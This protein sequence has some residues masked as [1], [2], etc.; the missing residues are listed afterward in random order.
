MAKKTSE[1]KTRR[2]A[3]IVRNVRARYDAAQLTREN[4]RH[5][6]NADAYDAVRANES[7]VRSRL[8]QNARYE[9]A[10]NSYAK[11]IVLTLA[12][13]LIGSGPRLQII[14]DN[15]SLNQEIEGRFEEW[16]RSIDL[17]GKL[18][19]MRMA[20]CQDG[21]AFGLM[22][23]N[24]AKNG[25]TLDLRLLEAD[26]VDSIDSIGGKYVQGIN[27]DENGNPVSY[28]VLKNHP[29]GLNPTY[30]DYIDVPAKFMLHW[31]RA[32]RP[33]QIRGV[34]EITPALPLFAHL[35]RY[36][37][38]VVTTAE[39]IAEFT[40]FLKSNGAPD[41]VPTDLRAA[42]GGD[43]AEVQ[44]E[45][46]MLTTLPEG[47]EP[48]QL[49]SEQPGTTYDM[50]KREILNE[51][52]RCLNIPYNI[53]ACNSSSYNYASGRLDHQTFFKSI[54]VDQSNCELAVVDPLFNAWLDEAERVYGWNLPSR[55]HQWFW[56]GL[57][58]VDPSKEADAQSTRLANNTTTLA[59]EYARQ[60]RD[61]EVEL[62][63]RAKEL[64]LC[65]K[66]GIPV[67]E[68]NKTTKVKEDEEESKKS[69]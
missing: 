19:T 27:F 6:A 66:L 3:S 54:S 67:S 22:Y 32:D 12:N 2:T 58:H 29:G 61:W 26:Q 65:K 20:R 42:L 35:R 21:E 10:N 4:S 31:F 25:I 7:S 18:R 68:L 46:G 62:R 34:P 51:I 57:E 53:A 38:A 69:K 56:D 28:S 49:R 11:G 24:T 43:F 59:I 9:V 33:G 30:G 8:R 13:Y 45:R 41:G 15:Q 55:K 64:E 50:F 44:V 48:F 52:A 1:N 17:A 39:I 37:L 47:W 23:S 16:S 40:M 14:S 63:Q 36:T 60:G 5:W